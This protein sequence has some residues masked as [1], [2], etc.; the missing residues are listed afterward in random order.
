MILLKEKEEKEDLEEI[1]LEGGG[2]DK[3][4]VIDPISTLFVEN[5]MGHMN[6]MNAK[7]HGR[8]SKNIERIRK[9]KKVKLHNKKKVNNLNLLIALFPIII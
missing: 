2:V 9:R 5:I 8:R 1:I 4:K 7:L 6:K 3:T